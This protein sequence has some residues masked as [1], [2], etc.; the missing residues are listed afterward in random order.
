MY[1]TGRALIFLER[2]SVKHII[3]PLSDQK[4]VN[5]PVIDILNADAQVGEQLVDAVVRWG[6][7]FIKAHGSGFTPDIIDNMFQIVSSNF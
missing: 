3:M 7:V 1:R 6:F 5:I 4:A 2:I